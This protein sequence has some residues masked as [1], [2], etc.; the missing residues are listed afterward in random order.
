MKEI[1]I[2]TTDKVVQLLQLKK[3]NRKTLSELLGVS[4]PTINERL[5]KHNW[6]KLE[7]E[8]INTL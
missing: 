2:Q 1:S 8:K 7:I 5:E 3:F 4:R 6:K